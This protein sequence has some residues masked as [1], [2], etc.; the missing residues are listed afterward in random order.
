MRRWLLTLALL[1][2]IPVPA[3]EA[4][5][6]R[7]GQ[8][9]LVVPVWPGARFDLTFTHSIFG[10]P[11]REQFAVSWTG[12]LVLTEVRSTDPRIIGY[13]DIPGAPTREQPGDVRIV[14]LSLA[15][16]RLVVRGTPIGGRAYDDGRCRVPLAAMAGDWGALELRVRLRPLLLRAVNGRFAHCPT[17]P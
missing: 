10:V 8:P 12:E 9:A 2:L 13:Y 1:L 17:Q 3:L 16:D 14:D 6:A 7:G 4:V 5:P 15:H 11:V